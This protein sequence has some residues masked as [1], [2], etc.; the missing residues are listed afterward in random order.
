M[1]WGQ[2][3]PRPVVTDDTTGSDDTTAH[4]VKLQPINA[5][6]PTS[7]IAMAQCTVETQI[8]KLASDLLADDMHYD[9]YINGSKIRRYL[10]PNAIAN[11]G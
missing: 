8:W 1:A 7:S 5:A 4:T 10:A 3:W 9:L 6:Y 2:K 11:L